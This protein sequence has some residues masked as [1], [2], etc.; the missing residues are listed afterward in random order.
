MNINLK[1]AEILNLVEGS[2]TFDLNFLVE[3]IKSLESATTNDIA[4]FLD[5]DESIFDPLSKELIKNSKACLIVASKEWIENKNYIIV[6]NP[7][8][9]LQKIVNFIQNKNNNHTISKNASIDNSAKLGNNISIG[10]FSTIGSNSTI[11]DNSVIDSQVFIG[12]DCKIGKNVKIYSGVAILKETIIG[13]N[14]IIQSGT[15]IGSDGYGYKVGRSGLSKIPQIGIVRIGNNVE[16]GAN[17]CIDRAAF[18]ETVL[19]DGVKL[20]NL[21]HIAHNVKVGPH[22]AIIALTA[23]AGG[24]TIGMGCQIGGQVGIKDHVKIGNQVKIVSKSGVMR[25]LADKEVVAGTPAVPFLE[26]K[27]IHISLLRLPKMLKFAN[28]LQSKIENSKNKKSFW[29]KLFWWF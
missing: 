20:D 24:V 13:D 17:C 7:L 10:N 16:I 21:V 14:C 9:A 8:E 28:E 1:V 26:W 19:S 3:D 25:D 11:G 29:R 6:S 27:K 15:V 4:F 23:I 2:T 5:P 12:N 22:T 18:D